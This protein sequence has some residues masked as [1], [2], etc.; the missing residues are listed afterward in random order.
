MPHHREGIQ[1]ELDKAY[2]EGHRDN[3]VIDEAVSKIREVKGVMEVSSS[4]EKF[5]SL[6]LPVEMEGKARAH[7]ARYIKETYGD[8]WLIPGKATMNYFVE[9]PQEA[10]SSM[11]DGNRYYFF[12][13]TEELEKYG[14]GEGFIPF[15]YWVKADNHFVYQGEPSSG[16]WNNMYSRVVLLKEK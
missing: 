13:P 8:K 10:P 1:N 5:K 9:N 4:G 6:E 14:E 15:F 7:V 2:D 11:K 16:I 3:K 12:G